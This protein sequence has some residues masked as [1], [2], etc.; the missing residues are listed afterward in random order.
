MNALQILDPGQAHLH[1]LPLQQLV[2]SVTRRISDQFAALFASL[3]HV[4]EATR[5][6]ALGEV[7]ETSRQLLARVLAVVRWL[8]DVG[9]VRARLPAAAS[10]VRHCRAPLDTAHV[11]ASDLRKYLS[12]YSHPAWDL[13]SALHVLSA[14]GNRLFPAA[15]QLRMQE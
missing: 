7:A 4:D 2:L 14:R 8:R 13:P 9:P 1:A 11:S 12:H 15:V 3:V 5:R 6:K 10:A